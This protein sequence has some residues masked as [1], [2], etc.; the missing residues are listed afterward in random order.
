M[1]AI[2]ATF[3]GVGCVVLAAGVAGAGEPLPPGM[4]GAGTEPAPASSP[5]RVTNQPLG[6]ALTP[7]GSVLPPAA[8]DGQPWIAQAAR[9]VY[10]QTGISARI[11]QRI[12]LYEQ[13]LIGTGTYLQLGAH[14]DK[15]LRLELLIQAGSQVTSLQQVCDGRF[16]W[17]HTRLDDVAHL[18]RIDLRRLREAMDEGQRSTPP[19]PAALWMELGGLP[20]LLSGLEDNFQFARPQAGTLGELPVWLL[21]GTWKP[22]Q[23]ARYLPP[24]A[25]GA[26]QGAAPDLSRLPRHVPASVRVVLGRTDLFPYRIDFLGPS[27]TSQ[28]NAGSGGQASAPSLLTIELFE[29]TLGAAIDPLRFVYKPGDIDVDDDTDRYIQR[30]GLKPAARAAARADRL[31]PP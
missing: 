22:D 2:F 27:A 1:K 7:G 15:L 24:D 6:G 28:R 18:S 10:S 23:L 20:K 9:M 26:R 8:G 3:A 31:L 16:L 4:P 21:Y 14:D 13:Q 19:A 25:K 17:V 29:V 5:A 12:N 30:L 11:R